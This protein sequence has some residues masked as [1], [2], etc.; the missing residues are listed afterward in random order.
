M[1]ALLQ[2]VS[3]ASVTVDNERIGRYFGFISCSDR[4]DD[5]FS[6]DDRAIFDDLAG[7]DLNPG[8]FDR[9]CGRHK[10]GPPID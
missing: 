6:N 7:L 1:R 3:E 4:F 8:A 10:I 9:Q 2:R 5:A